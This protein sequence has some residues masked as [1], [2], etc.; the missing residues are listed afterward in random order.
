MIAASGRLG[1]TIF[2][3]W[4]EVETTMGDL[5]IHFDCPSCQQGCRAT[6]DALGK[7]GACENCGARFVFPAPPDESADTNRTANRPRVHTFD[8]FLS[9]HWTDATIAWQIYD[10]LTSAGHRVWFDRK[11][12]L[13]GESW[14]AAIERGLSETHTFIVLLTQHAPRKWVDAEVGAAIRRHYNDLERQYRII[15]VIAS[16]KHSDPV[17]SV[18]TFLDAFQRHTLE[19]GDNAQVAQNSF[20]DLC[21]ALQ[22]TKEEAFPA[23]VVENPY[24]GLEPFGLNDHHLF[25]GRD[26][27][28]AELL[29]CL[30][31]PRCRWL[32]LEGGS[33]SGKSSLIRAGLLPALRRRLRTEQDRDWAVIVM[34]P[35]HN[36]I[37]ELAVAWRQWERSEDTIPDD[38]VLAVQRLAQIESVLSQPD[39]LRQLVALTNERSPA[40]FLL[41]VD[42]FEE[43][44]TLSSGSG[45]DTSPQQIFTQLIKSVLTDADSPLWLATTIRSDFLNQVVS[46]CEWSSMLN[47]AVRYAVGPLTEAGLQNAI[48]QP[49]RMAGGR[50]ET[51][52]PATDPLLQRLVKETTAGPGR[53]P[54]LS[55]V[56]WSLW[57]EARQ[58]RDNIPTLRLTDLERLGSL[59]KAITASAEAVLAPLS[60][61]QCACVRRILLELVSVGT[62]VRDVRRS[63]EKAALLSAV[64]DPQ[65]ENLLAYLSGGRLFGSAQVDEHPR[66]VVVHEPDGTGG[67]STPRVDL[68]HEALLEEWSRLREWVNGARRDLERRADIETASLTWAK[69]G[70]R[71]TDLPGAGLLE[72]YKRWDHEPLP[73]SEAAARFLHRTTIHNDLLRRTS[74]RRVRLVIGALS[75]GLLVVTGLALFAFQKAD[76]AVQQQRSAEAALKAETIALAEAETNGKRALE[77]E[78]RALASEKLAKERLARIEKG[79]GAAV[80][81]ATLPQLAAALDSFMQNSGAPL[82]KVSTFEDANVIAGRDPSI[83]KGMEDLKAIYDANRKDEK[84]IRAMLKPSSVPN[85]IIM[86]KDSDRQVRLKAAQLLRIMGSDAK[87]AIP[88]LIEA[89]KDPDDLVRGATIGAIAAMGRD[90]LPALPALRQALNKEDALFGV[91][92][93]TAA[94][95]ISQFGEAAKPAVPDL[96]TLLRRRLPGGT[97]G[98]LAAVIKLGPIASDAVPAVI[99]TLKETQDYPIVNGC[100]N[101]L[102]AIGPA[103]KPALPQ[104]IEILKGDDANLRS[105]A[106]SVLAKLG[107]SAEPALPQLILI[108]RGGN[109]E[110]RGLVCEILCNCPTVA[111]KALP[112]LIRASNG[113]EGVLD[114]DPPP[115]FFKPEETDLTKSNMIYWATRALANLE[116][117]E[118]S[119]GTALAE[120]LSSPSNSTRSWATFGLERMGAKAAPYLPQLR[121]A[122]QHETGQDNRTSMGRVI[123]KIAPGPSEFWYDGSIAPKGVQHWVRLD[124]GNWESK[125][126]DDTTIRFIVVGLGDDDKS[127][128]VRQLPAED[129]EVL[130]PT[131]VDGTTISTR[132]VG[133]KEWRKL[134]VV[135]AKP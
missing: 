2:D 110:C 43:L 60:R 103:A 1:K 67:N 40:Q 49:L 3:P 69:A 84:A 10:R 38:P 96:V 65:A 32:Q 16:T 93:A 127:I 82:A 7:V 114:D 86:L 68:V 33:G 87:T 66:L 115:V 47:R 122:R 118:S 28:V 130:I 14:L 128:I 133:E 75:F 121:K 19:V 31:A 113:N 15:P 124:P 100:L 45:E 8:I 55:H 132:K 129:I 5:L 61:E 88:A 58:R 106:L 108:L 78:Q 72:H 41:V 95:A 90:A 17:A 35:A 109:Q 98:A 57:R 18:G 52:D 85:L 73:L 29:E 48:L 117:P 70:Q 102:A 83:I 24:R 26:K 99:E 77:N 116:P 25:F 101:A 105:R 94:M 12:I 126:P 30:R 50:L 71:D 11:C 79:V 9:Y 4:T 44:F 63:V 51:D 89:I 42:Q 131:S 22:A 34:R 111:G 104:L 107:P 23:R 74:R 112:D 59:A 135:R 76:E 36:P 21:Q 56:L 80:G 119:A 46:D 53:L 20:V 37:K 92:A 27:E 62:G 120:R 125:L 123:A 13:E 6:R 54:L 97:V 64:Q 39:G 91:I 134:A 81:E